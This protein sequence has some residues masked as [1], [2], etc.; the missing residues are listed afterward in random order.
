MHK[1]VN[2]VKPYKEYA[3]SACITNNKRKLVFDFTNVDP[4][5]SGS[6]LLAWRRNHLNCNAMQ[7][8]KND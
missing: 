6:N 5:S 4:Q 8:L 1:H 7:D 2:K 3:F